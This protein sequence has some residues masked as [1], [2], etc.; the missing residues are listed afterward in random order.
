MNWIN[1]MHRW[2]KTVPPLLF[3]L[4]PGMLFLKKKT[5]FIS[6]IQYYT[7][8]KRSWP[9]TLIKL[10]GIFLFEVTVVVQS[11]TNVVNRSSRY[12]LFGYSHLWY[13]ESTR[14]LYFWIFKAYK[15]STN[16]TTKQSS[17]AIY[18]IY[19]QDIKWNIIHYWNNLW[20]N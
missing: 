11:Q 9:W 8:F 5:T 16:E 6:F 7:F 20:L 1:F 19:I 17:S 12:L 15:T 2:L 13:F 14:F 10:R 4:D 3:D 18:V